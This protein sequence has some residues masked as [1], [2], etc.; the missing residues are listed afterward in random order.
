MI[1]ESRLVDFTLDQLQNLFKLFFHEWL[2]IN[3]LHLE[4]L[5]VLSELHSIERGQK[6]EYGLLY[7]HDVALTFIV[8]F[9][10]SLYGLN[11]LYAILTGHL[12]V[13]QH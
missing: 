6:H 7:M 1:N 10:V 2:F 8:L 11:H 3:C 9:Y 5:N 13:E 4:L 12:K